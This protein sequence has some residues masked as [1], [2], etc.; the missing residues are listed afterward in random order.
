MNRLQT[1]LLVAAFG[2]VLVA[3][4]AVAFAARQG[5]RHEFLKFQD[6]ERQSMI[7]RR[8]ETTTQVAAELSQL[9]CDA[10]VVDDVSR[11]LDANDALLVLTADGKRLVASGGE[12][13]RSVRDL[14]AGV[15]NGELQVELTQA[16]GREL[17]RGSLKFALRGT[18]LVLADGRPALA[19][20]V[21][22]PS[23]EAGSPASTF[24]GSLDRW[25]LG[26]TLMASLLALGATWAATRTALAPIAELQRATADLAAGD[27]SRRVATSGPEEIAALAGSFNRMAAELDTQRHLRRNLVHDVAHELRTPLTALRCRLE[28]VQDGLVSA[29]PGTVGGLHEQVRHLSQLVDDLQELAQAESRELRLQIAPID[30]EPLISSS[31]RAAGLEGDARVRV[32]SRSEAMLGDVVRMRQVLTNLLTNAA[33]HTP[34]GGS[35]TIRTRSSNHRV[36]VDVQNSG[37]ALDAEQLARIFDRFYRTD[38]SRQRD[39]GGTGLGLAIVKH[40]VEAQGGRVRAS[41]DAAGVTVGFD[42]S[43]TSSL[44]LLPS[45]PSA[46]ASGA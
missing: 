18:P 42:A 23:A 33:R 37:S 25:L 6:G 12:A 26:A 10:A 2:V 4:A 29:S 24:V 21:P 43:A 11:R 1:R 17:Q 19:F 20:V 41:S 14:S 34:A 28:A 32:D 15:D 46:P 40:L 30:L 27:F 7:A 16:F 45:A 8:L 9:C 36:L 13:L 5:A 39:T 22:I 31:I 38:P 35:I 3:V 44:Q